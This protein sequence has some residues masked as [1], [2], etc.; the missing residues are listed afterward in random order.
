MYRQGRPLLQPPVAPRPPYP[1]WYR[2][3]NLLPKAWEA[4]RIGEDAQIHPLTPHPI[5]PASPLLLEELKLIQVWEAMRM[6][7]DAQIA[8][9]TPHPSPHLLPPHNHHLQGIESAA[10]GVGGDEDRQGRSDRV[11]HGAQQTE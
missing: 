4:M 2:E 5:C 11:S 7:K 6:G 1:C 9:P 3:L 8:S 10:E